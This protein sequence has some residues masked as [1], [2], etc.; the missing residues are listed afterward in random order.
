[1]GGGAELEGVAQ[2]EQLLWLLRTWE[3][4]IGHAGGS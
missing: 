4:G 2:G 3:V 1:M